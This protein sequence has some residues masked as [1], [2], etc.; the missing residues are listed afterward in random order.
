MSQVNFRFNEIASK[1]MD[2]NPESS[3]VLENVVTDDNLLRCKGTKSYRGS[4]QKAPAF[5]ESMIEICTGKGSAVLDL[6]GAVGKQNANIPFSSCKVASEWTSNINSPFCTGSSVQACELSGRHILALEEDP[7]AFN[8]FLS[9]FAV[10]P[11]A[12]IGREDNRMLSLKQHLE[13][14]DGPYYNTSAQAS[15]SGSSRGTA[16]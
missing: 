4:K 8:M 2:W 11:S 5:M 14:L 6:T 3:D 13:E 12:D 1:V 9:D 15:L 7:S 10:E 16:S